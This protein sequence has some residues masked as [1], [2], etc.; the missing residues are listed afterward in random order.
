M[1]DDPTE[2]VDARMPGASVTPRTVFALRQQFAADLHVPLLHVLVDVTA[3]FV[4][5]LFLQDVGPKSLTEVLRRLA[6][7]G[8]FARAY[9]QIVRED[10][11]HLFRH[12]PFDEAW[13]LSWEHAI[14]TANYGEK[15]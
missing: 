15:S 1:S 7:D 3:E 5:V 6:G 10:K 14:A 13:D 11:A 2:V 12:L 9:V 4:Y 8:W